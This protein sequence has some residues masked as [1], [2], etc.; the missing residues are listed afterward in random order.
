MIVQSSRAYSRTWHFAI[1]TN[2]KPKKEKK[3]EGN[4]KSIL[5][6]SSWKRGNSFEPI[7][8]KTKILCV[9]VC[10]KIDSDRIN[11][12]KLRPLYIER[13]VPCKSQ[14]K[15]WKENFV[16]S[17]LF[18]FTIFKRFSWN[19]FA[20]RNENVH[21]CCKNAARISRSRKFETELR[22]NRI[23]RKEGCNNFEIVS[24]CPII[25]MKTNWCHY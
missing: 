8:E 3:K 10:R 21:L 4:I 5:V 22:K 2:K 24:C 18:F 11:V 14:S 9:C 13:I 19:E 16:L 7:A 23:T 12:L 17:F 15:H 20:I 1:S 25:V 6:R